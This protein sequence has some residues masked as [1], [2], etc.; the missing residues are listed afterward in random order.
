[1][2][3]G[4]SRSDVTIP[5]LLEPVR[6]Y[7]R[8]MDVTDPALVIALIALVAVTLAMLSSHLIGRATTEVKAAF[9]DEDHE[10]SRIRPRA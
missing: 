7:V 9:S 6:R 2:R 10:L 8:G 1:M 4:A 5:T 3:P